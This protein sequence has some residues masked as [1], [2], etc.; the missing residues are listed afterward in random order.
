MLSNDLDTQR[1][2][3]REHTE[4]LAQEARN[5]W[6]ARDLRKAKQ[7]GRGRNRV[8]ALPTALVLAARRRSPQAEIGA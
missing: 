7:T 5:E 3:T 2:L 8:L 4:R 1:F 6:L